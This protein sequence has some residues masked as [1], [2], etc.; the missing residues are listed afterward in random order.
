MQ[1]KKIWSQNKLYTKK[2]RKTNRNFLHF[3]IIFLQDFIE[4]LA[5]K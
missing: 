4:L 3:V 1:R 2:I 5:K